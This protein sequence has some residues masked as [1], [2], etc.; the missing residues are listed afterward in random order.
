MVDMSVPDTAERVR[1]ILQGFPKEAESAIK[2]GMTKGAKVYRQETD[3]AILGVYAIDPGTFKSGG[4]TRVDYYNASASVSYSGA[5]IPLFDFNATPRERIYGVTVWAQQL[6]SG[7]GEFPHAFIAKMKSGHIGIFER[8]G[9]R[10]PEDNRERISEIMA[11]ATAQMAERSEISGR[12][13]EAAR[14]AAVIEMEEAVSRI[15]NG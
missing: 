2:R 3:K 9:Q 11:V 13:A 1:N 6:K 4:T 10:R 5:K 7:G 15:L 8:N 14:E 12:A